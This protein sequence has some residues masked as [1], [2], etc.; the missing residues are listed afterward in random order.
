MFL[1]PRENNEN[2]GN[3]AFP[4]IGLQQSPRRLPDRRKIFIET[5]EKRLTKRD[6]ENTIYSTL[7]RKYVYIC[8][9]FAFS[10]L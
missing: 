6:A 2:G 5:A 9:L 3:E 8:R 4:F 10:S 7:K 1:F